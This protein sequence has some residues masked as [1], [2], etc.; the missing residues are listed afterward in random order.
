MPAI[1]DFVL[2]FIFSFIVLSL[3][4]S[5]WP[6]YLF[7]SLEKKTRKEKDQI[8]S[9]IEKPT[10]VAWSLIAGAALTLLIFGIASILHRIPSI[11]EQDS[12]F[13]TKFFERGWV[14]YFILWCFFLG[15]FHLYQ[16]REIKFKVLRNARNEDRDF[17]EAA[18]AGITSTSSDPEKDDIHKFLKIVEEISEGKREGGVYIEKFK[19]LYSKWQK[20]GKVDSVELLKGELLEA[21]EEDVVIS[22]I[23]VR[24]SEWAL[25][26]LGFLGTVI[27]IGSAIVSM[28]GGVEK[29]FGEG[30][31]TE[32]AFNLF[33][34]GFKDLA[35]AFDTTFLGLFFL[36]I[37]G[38]LH[39]IIRKDLTSELTFSK[40]V[41]TYSVTKLQSADSLGGYFVDA[42]TPEMLYRLQRIDKNT[43]SVIDIFETIIDEH[44]DFGE[45]KKILFR[46]I[47]YA[48]EISREIQALAQKKPDGV[49]E[50]ILNTLSVSNIKPIVL[51]LSI[52]DKANNTPFIQL[53]EEGACKFLKMN[54]SIEWLSIES[55]EQLCLFCDETGYMQ[56]F[57]INDLR[58]SSETNFQ[59]YTSEDDGKD[60]SIENRV[61]VNK[62][63]DLNPNDYKIIHL[64]DKKN[65]QDKY[66]I[67]NRDG[68]NYTIEL[69]V[70]NSKQIKINP[71]KI[72]RDI[73]IDLQQ[74]I[75]SFSST[76]PNLIAIGQKNLIQIC[77]LTETRKRE[78]RLEHEVEYNLNYEFKAEITSIIQIEFISED[79]L[80]ILAEDGSIYYW[81]FTLVP[82][83]RRIKQ[84]VGED[85]TM[86][87]KGAGNWFALS[88]KNKG[89]LH[90]WRIK[91]DKIQQKDEEFRVFVDL[92][93][94]KTTFDGKYVVGI[95]E[96]NVYAWQ[97]PVY[98]VDTLHSK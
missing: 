90:L 58:K 70:S 1:L 7:E 73:N 82:E 64:R 35:V 11:A 88:S 98:Y 8:Q 40:K 44:P 71:Q 49:S 41:L 56:W 18:L 16:I 15:L 32:F 80:L 66:L 93:E 48:H 75:I 28:K 46:P 72:D 92:K 60:N 54:N 26:L 47:V 22:L 81:Y 87:A 53:I 23:P 52:H 24:L 89:L 38:A 77:S 10:K 14:P 86:F 21:E 12:F 57:N 4:R 31:L 61:L 65:K 17:I 36:I 42:M 5:R 37:I 95:S 3:W 33:T 55:R 51:I 34:E 29:T 69:I 96:N 97:F 25:P 63:I 2:V 91:R 30:R 20:E 94:L 74:E 67:F 39:F 43:H 68:A 9:R 27:G 84:A 6:L 62:L 13:Y 59:F 50:T 76:A 45:L 19:I 78:G 83:P 85:L 79:Q